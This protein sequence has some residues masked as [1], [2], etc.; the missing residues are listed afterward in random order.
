VGLAYVIGH[1]KPLM[2]TIETFGT[3]TVD[4]EALYAFKDKLLDTSVRGIIDTLGLAQPIYSKTSAYGHFGKKD[5]PW[6]QIA[7]L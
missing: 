5:L 6:E 3:A 4:D 2:Q 1:P 7:K